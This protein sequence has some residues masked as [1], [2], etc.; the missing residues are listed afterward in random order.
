MMEKGHGGCTRFSGALFRL[1][2]FV[3]LGYH[4]VRS[5][6][7]FRLPW[8]SRNSNSAPRPS[9]SPAAI[10]NMLHPPPPLPIK[11]WAG[12]SGS[13]PLLSLSAMGLVLA[14]SAR[15]RRQW[16]QIGRTRQVV[17]S[18][19][20]DFSRPGRPRSGGDGPAGVQTGPTGTGP[21]PTPQ[22]GPERTHAGPILCATLG[23]S[24]TCHRRA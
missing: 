23:P 6:M 2:L 10:I 5:S 12:S 15:L 13:S 1:S 24:K 18:C 3:V 16:K 21:S 22:D 4:G 9:S 8:Q 20:A 14:A 19:P 11:E 7:H 17:R